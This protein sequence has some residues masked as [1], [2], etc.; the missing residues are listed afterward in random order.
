MEQVTIRASSLSTWARC[1]AEALYRLDNPG[2]GEAREPHVAGWIGSMAHAICADDD[3][4]LP[5]KRQRYDK[6]TPTFAYG[7]EQALR[8][9]L[10][11]RKYCREMGWNIVGREVPKSRTWPQQSHGLELSGTCDLIVEVGNEMWIL[12]L[13]T[14]ATFHPA[15]IQLG[16]YALLN[17][18]AQQ[19]GVIHLPRVSLAADQPPPKL[20]LRPALGL[21]NAAAVQLTRIEAATFMTGPIVRNP[22]PHCAHCL[23]TDCAVRAD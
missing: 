16:A 1:E 11:L 14:G 8:M 5:P 12:D 17:P 4:P 7:R 13:K 9:G 2:Q 18:A 19:V 20:L 23:D 15:W 10:E 3:L 22:G 21:A 6:L